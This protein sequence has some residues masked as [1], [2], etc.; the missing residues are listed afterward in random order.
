LVA[1]G[2]PAFEGLLAVLMFR[3]FRLSVRLAQ[4]R[5]VAG[6]VAIIVLAL[7]PV[8]ATGAGLV[9]CLAGT[10]TATGQAWWLGALARA[11]SQLV[12]A[13]FVLAWLGTARSSAP[14]PRLG[15]ALPV[16]AAQGALSCVLWFAVDPVYR[17]LLVYPLLA[18]AG[19][20]SDVRMT[21]TANALLVVL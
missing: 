3:H 12:F 7:P 14:K 18:G 6:L 11:T 2:V 21:S 4:P 20:L 15:L 13:P 1:G 10:M 19:L 16:M 5:D 9:Q 8:S 17:P